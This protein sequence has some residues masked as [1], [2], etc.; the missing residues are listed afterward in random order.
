MRIRTCI[1]RVHTRATQPHSLRSRGTCGFGPE[2]NKENRDV[3]SVLKKKA[4]TGENRSPS[5]SLYFNSRYTTLHS[6]RS[7][8]ERAH[9][10]LSSVAFVFG[11][12][13]LGMRTVDANRRR[14]S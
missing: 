14:A 10:Y 7:G 1:G 12:F 9:D 4:V 2:E 8:D 13:V 5:V 11:R 6:P 3:H